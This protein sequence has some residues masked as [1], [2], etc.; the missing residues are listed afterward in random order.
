[1]LS[2]AES[3]SFTLGNVM[4]K[5]GIAERTYRTMIDKVHCLIW[6]SAEAV[7]IAVYLNSCFPYTVVHFRRIMEDMEKINS[8]HL[9]VFD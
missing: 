8:R 2:I 1:M 5:N 6:M 9:N 4:V 3:L 7:N